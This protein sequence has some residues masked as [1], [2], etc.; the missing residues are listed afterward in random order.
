MSLPVSTSRKKRPAEKKRS[1]REK[2]S[3]KSSSLEE[4][5]EALPPH[6][7]SDGSRARARLHIGR[8]PHGTWKLSYVTHAG[9]EVFRLEEDSL[10]PLVEGALDKLEEREAL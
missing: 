7:E 1:A 8:L 6:L 3:A 10:P 4:K 2:R 9:R 5:L